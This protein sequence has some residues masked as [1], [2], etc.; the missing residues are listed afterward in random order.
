VQIHVCISRINQTFFHRLTP[1][2]APS[3]TEVLAPTGTCFSATATRDADEE[4]DESA[5]SHETA[6]SLKWH[7]FLGGQL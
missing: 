2:P 1:F 3:A 4:D 5:W 6:A 7:L